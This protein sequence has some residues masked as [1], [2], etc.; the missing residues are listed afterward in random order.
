MYGLS[1]NLENLNNDVCDSL[2]S[3][4]DEQTHP[5]L[6]AS[7]LRELKWWKHCMPS[8]LQAE[9]TYVRTVT[10]SA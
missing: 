7:E 3:W 1:V 6:S 5:Q 9:S 8:L 4:L 2:I 10:S